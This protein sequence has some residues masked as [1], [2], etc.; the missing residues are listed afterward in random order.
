MLADIDPLALV[1]HDLILF[2]FVLASYDCSVFQDTNVRWDAIGGLGSHVKTLHEMVV[3]PLLY[4]EL[5]ARFSVTP[6]RGVLFHGPPGTGKTLVARALANTCSLPGKPVAFFM[7]KGADCL[8]K[9]VG[10]AERQLRLLFEQAT[11]MQPSIIFFDEIDGLAPVRSARQDQIH[12]SIVSTLLALMDGLDSRGKVIVIGAT[13]R[14][15]SIDPALRR[16]GRFDRELLFALPSLQARSEILKIHTKSWNPSLPESLINELAS[17]SAGYCGA[18]LKAL[19]TEASLLAMR[20]AFPQ[21]YDLSNDISNS[22]LRFLVDPNQINI[23]AQDFALALENITPASHRSTLSFIKQLPIN[24][25]PLLGN[26]VSKIAQLSAAIF[27]LGAKSKS[28]Q[29][30]AGDIRDHCVA[31]KPLL[32]FR[33]RL[34]IDGLP[35]SGQHHVGAA[36][37]HLFENYPMA[38][39]DLPSVLGDAQCKSPEETCLRIFRELRR[40]A[41]AVLY[42]PMVVLWWETAEAALRASLQM[43]IENI[44]DDVPI[45]LIATSELPHE[46]MCD[47]LKSIFQPSFSARYEIPRPTEAE[48]EA[49]FSPLVDLINQPI[50][51][52][53]TTP[54]SELPSLPLVPISNEESK[55]ENLEISL[56]EAARADLA[57]EDEI[58]LATLRL[59]LRGVLDRLLKVFKSFEFMEEDKCNEKYGEVILQPLTLS[60]I[61][62]KLNER[63]YNCV[64]QFLA[65]I[66]LIVQNVKELARYS[67]LENSPRVNK[68]YHLQ[69]TALTLVASEVEPKVAR[70]C[71][72][73]A[74][75]LGT[76]TCLNQLPSQTSQQS[77]T[78]QPDQMSLTSVCP[79]SDIPKTS[80]NPATNSRILE[81]EQDTK[82]GE[83][84]GIVTANQTNG[85]SASN[86]APAGISCVRKI[87]TTKRQRVGE[88]APSFSSSLLSISSDS[89]P[90]SFATNSS[91]IIKQSV[92]I[93][94]ADLRR[95]FQSLLNISKY[96]TLDQ[97]EVLHH[98]LNSCISSHS[99]N[100]DKSRCLLELKELLSTIDSQI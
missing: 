61:Q 59:R 24:L 9:W 50:S 60:A 58:V 95:I 21:L 40:N 15:D 10:E 53:M 70:R 90:G 63:K 32:P 31:M 55:Q 49:F 22:G 6:P 12:A 28:Q 19:C 42:W 93:D 62:R 17:K 73:I 97:L 43:L 69:D 89:N 26:A 44:P 35:G 99:S 48:V 67:S 1:W 82:L 85:I 39:L 96:Y 65:D 64:G 46:D 76:R 98:K 81:S 41:P 74:S 66:D 94:T 20:R 16:P 33:P 100:V 13:N 14:V 23:E 77:E 47:E 80:G 84:N 72:E 92:K 37:L 54:L 78:E 2:C 52:P 3:L 30:S 34:L 18:D 45:F 91:S 4:P 51:F 56:S 29:A 7:R 83:N 75:R 5:F 27:P 86:N 57:R 25:A 79:T 87:G 8:S 11:K 71:Q 36:V 68:A 88:S 38:S